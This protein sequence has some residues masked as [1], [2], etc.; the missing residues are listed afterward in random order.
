MR[1]SLC[2]DQPKAKRPKKD[3]SPQE[4][5]KSEEAEKLAQHRAA[6]DNSEKQAKK[7]FAKVQQARGQRPTSHAHVR[8]ST[9]AP[10]DECTLTKTR[11]DTR[12]K[13]QDGRTP[14]HGITRQRPQL[15]PSHHTP[16]FT[17]THA[18]A[19]THTHTHTHTLSRISATAPPTPHP[20]PC[21]AQHKHTSMQR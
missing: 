17:H 13:N 6:K 16:A 11:G 18:C 8:P 14:T 10:L 5:P 3:V 1:G 19:H 20:A 12:D 15:T 4:K 7:V 21:P 2:E 9:H